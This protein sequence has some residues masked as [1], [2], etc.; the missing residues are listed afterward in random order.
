VVENG[1]CCG[2]NI[3]IIY[4]A[5]PN[6]AVTFLVVLRDASDVKYSLEDELVNIWVVQWERSIEKR[7]KDSPQLEKWKRPNLP[8][9]ETP[10]SLALTTDCPVSR[11]AN[12]RDQNN[13]PHFEALPIADGSVSHLAP[14]PVVP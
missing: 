13:D 8:E 6:E 14:G 3:A 7:S 12:S 4:I 1:G 5:F 9:R 11:L 2:N 10:A